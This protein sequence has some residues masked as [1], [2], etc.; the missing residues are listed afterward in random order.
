MRR[1]IFALDRF[2]VQGAWMV[3]SLLQAFCYVDGMFWVGPRALI[4]KGDVDRDTSRCFSM[5]GWVC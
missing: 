5:K 1:C 3:E 4:A 2:F